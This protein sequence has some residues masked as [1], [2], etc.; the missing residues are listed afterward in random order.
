MSPGLPAAF[1]NHW[2]YP[3]DLLEA[4][5]V[6]IERAILAKSHQEPRFEGGARARQVSEQIGLG[7]GLEQGVD[8]LFQAGDVFMEYPQLMRQAKQWRWAKYWV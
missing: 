2:G 7:M 1:L 4:G 5:R 8:L 3:R 6:R